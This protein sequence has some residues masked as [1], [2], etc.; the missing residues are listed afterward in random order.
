[1]VNVSSVALPIKL[2]LFFLILCP[3]VYLGDTLLN[4][5][6]IYIPTLFLYLVINK[7]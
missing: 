4:F 1:M 2:L 6:D 7:K 5:C 3:G